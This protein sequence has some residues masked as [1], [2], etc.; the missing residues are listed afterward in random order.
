MYIKNYEKCG[1]PNLISYYLLFVS[2]QMNVR[3]L[4]TFITYW[5]KAGYPANTDAVL[6]NEGLSRQHLSFLS[7]APK[8]NTSF[9][10]TGSNSIGTKKK[11]KNLSLNAFNTL[12][13]S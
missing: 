7:L 1:A 8:Y 9:W 5:L 12:G 4:Y 13:G 3:F 6:L 10:L 11:Y 2:H